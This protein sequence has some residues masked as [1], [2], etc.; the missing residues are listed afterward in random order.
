MTTNINQT[1]TRHDQTTTSEQII[2]QK[3]YYKTKG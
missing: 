1:R 3:S 2:Q